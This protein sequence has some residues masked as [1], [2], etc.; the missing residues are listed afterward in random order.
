MV[1]SSLKTRIT[2]LFPLSITLVLIGLLFLIQHLLQEYIKESISTQQFQIVANLADE[3][4]RNIAEAQKP[5]IALASKITPGLISD[6]QE[7]YA[8]L[9]ERTESTWFFDNGVFLFDSRGRIIAE[10]PQGVSRSGRDFSFREYMQVTFSTKTPYVSEPY[11]S[12][13][14]NHPAV[15]ITVPILN[16]D[17]S[18]LAVLG[19]S[20]DLLQSNFLG[21]LSQRK[22]GKTGYVF[23]V[24]TRRTIIVHPD[25]NRIMTRDN[26]PKDNQ[27]LDRALKGFDGT[28]E[29]V[30]SQGLETLTTFKRLKSKEWIIGA[31]F[32]LIEAYQ[33]VKQ[34]KKIFLVLLPLLSL[35]MF[36]LMRRYLDRLTEPVIQ[37]TRHVATLSGKEGE[38]RF[39][40]VQGEDEAATLGRVF[41]DLIRETDRQRQQLEEELK[42]HELADFQ[43][44]R[45]NEYLQALHDTTM[46]LI[47]RLDVATVLQMIVSRSGRLI[48]TEHCFLYLVN[49]GDTE[50]NM[51]YQSGIYNSLTHH[52]VKRGEGV[53]GRVWLEGEPIRVSNYSQWEGRLPAADR[54]LLH[55][56]AGVPIKVGDKVAGVLGLAF[57]EPG[58]VFDDQQMEA[59]VQFSHL[60]S[61]ALENARLN[62]ESQHELAERKRAEENLRKLSVAVEQNPASIIITDTAGTIEYVNPHFT[63]LTGYSLEEAVGRNPGFLKTG[64]TSSEEYRNLWETISGGRVWHGEFHNRKK[65]G[66]LYWEQ[67]LI[68]PIRDEHGDI[69]HFIAIKE[70]ITQRKQL[71]V[72]LRH[73]QKMDAI[74]QLAGGIAHD[75]N[76]ILTAIIGYASIMQLKLPDGSPL[77]KNAAQIALTAERGA[78]LTQGLLAFSRKQAS[79]PVV[80]DLN[81][82]IN[83]VHQLLLRLISEDIHLEINLDPQGLPVLADSGQIEQVLMNLATN[84]RDVLPQGGAIVVT[85][86]EITIETDF[87]I[88]NGFGSPGRYALL[89]FR[90]NGNGMGPD[91]VK[92]IFD[93]FYTTK[94]LGKGTGLGLSIVYGI[95]K[96]HNGNI[97]CHS[98]IGLGTIFEIYLPLLGE[99]PGVIGEKPL[100]TV[101]SDTDGSCILLAEDN[102]AIRTLT[103]EILEEFG[104]TVFEAIDGEDALE[105]FRELGTRISLVILDVIMPKMNGGAVYD[106]IQN[107]MPHLP[108]L[109]CSGYA[110]DLLVSQGGLEEGVNYLRKPFAPKELL[111][112]IREVLDNGH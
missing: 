73:S 28:G 14:S 8:F 21:G 110:Q 80:V 44:Q 69:T 63:E 112:K 97:V 98:S 93:P 30:N 5:L 31:N 15:M 24:D 17:D 36:W 35:S 91:V 51:V 85:T 67:A 87:V 108:V 33:P 95:V 26:D 61:L 77:Q 101:E 48:G 16:A 96:E 42:R 58:A 100:D 81:E 11:I 74:G 65:D 49:S 79:N 109:F 45:H 104:Y 32:P 90:D 76:N 39:I 41:N 106:A 78:T 86:E 88:A 25:K 83:R 18:V 64:E 20:I 103:R 56:M 82:I 12:S 52:S 37:L 27:F 54:M 13:Q 10:L 40:L 43:M 55:A 68:A 89:T 75:F 1:S 59:L 6:P 70:D 3:V 50:L 29:R 47:K 53:S 62:E 7:A 92:H 94:E 46:G 84:A 66:D 22:I 34:I 23:L 72:Q 4:D 102:E 60:A 111:M 107:S 57:I 71:E 19:G 2:I 9:L 99:T 105:K 38:A